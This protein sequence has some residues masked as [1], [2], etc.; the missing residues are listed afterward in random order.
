MP[1]DLLSSLA[2]KPQ[3]E[4]SGSDSAFRFD[5]QKDWAFCR[6]IR[7]HIAGENYLVAFEFHDDVVFL[8]P[9]DLPT[10]V[11]FLQVKTSKAVSARRLS[12]LTSRP[13]GA[14]SILAKMVSNFDGIC[15]SQNIQII[16]VSNNVY[17][18]SEEDICADDLEAKFRGKLLEKLQEEIS[19]FDEARLKK[20]H[21]KVTGVSLDAMRSF[22]D[23]EAMELFCQK[24]GEDHGLNVRTWV[25]L[26]QS[27]IRRKN[28]HPSDAIASAEELVEH[29]C[30]SHEFVEETLHTMHAKARD[31][32]DINFVS[33][34]LHAA[35]WN[36]L[37]IFRLQKRIPQAS[38]DFYDPTNKEVRDLSISI[39][40]LSVDQHGE[41]K[42]LPLFLSEVADAL[43]PVAGSFN[44]YLERDYLFALGVLVYYEEI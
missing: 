27:E 8:A 24:F 9:S 40:A 23:G 38:N 1:D 13:K 44:P 11:E 30:I 4:V 12:S 43:K 7:K 32:V 16:L 34:L 22:L 2:Q 5:Y 28:N 42:E 39:K 3:R 21:F 36:S 19:G 25:R 15:S 37:D 10:D 18:F 35:S 29:K 6:M 26:L 41:T 33:Q 20:L 31:C 17:E 14:S